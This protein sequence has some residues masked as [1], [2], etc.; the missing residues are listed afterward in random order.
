MS[1][2][3]NKISSFPEEV[4][5]RISKV[6]GNVDKFYATVYLIAKNEH[7]NEEEKAPNWE[8]RRKIIHAYQERIKYLLA[9]LDLPANDIIADIKS[10]YLEDYVNYK[11]IDFD[12]TNE[13]FI[14]IIKRIG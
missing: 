8:T 14:E 9:E 2:I 11:D 4:K 5:S 3:K 10:D 13:E 7:I 1:E 6:F 12:M